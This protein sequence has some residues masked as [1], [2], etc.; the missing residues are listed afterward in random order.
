MSAC[1]GSLMRG[2]I[3]DVF[4]SAAPGPEVRGDFEAPRRCATS[5]SSEGRH[6]AVWWTRTSSVGTLGHTARMSKRR[7]RPHCLTAPSTA[8]A[9]T[10]H[11]IGVAT[12][13]ALRA[14]LAKR[15]E[16]PWQN[17][18]GGAVRSTNQVEASDWL[19]RL[20]AHQKRAVKP[21]MR[22]SSAAYS[23]LASSKIGRSA[24]ASFRA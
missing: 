23:F 24:S 18:D 13:V 17:G 5:R 16:N 4:G 8:Q 9:T 2:S 20:L 7:T 22:T 1:P 19:I 3:A 11:T 6:D 21:P 15:H 14:Q 12:L 10:S